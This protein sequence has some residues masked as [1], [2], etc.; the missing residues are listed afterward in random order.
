MAETPN[1][2]STRHSMS[3]S[4]SWTIAFLPSDLLDFG[5]PA[6]FIRIYNT[7]G[8]ALHF[9]LQDPVTTGHDFVAGC[10]AL[11]LSD[12]PAAGAIRLLTTSSSCTSRPIVGVSAWASA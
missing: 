8:D 11:V 10:S 12:I 7:C 4:S 1:A 5:F 2:Y 6:K 9:S 3:A